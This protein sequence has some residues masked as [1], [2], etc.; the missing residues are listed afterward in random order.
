MELCCYSWTYIGSEFSK[1]HCQDQLL[2]TVR[3]P[4]DCCYIWRKLFTAL[5][6]H[7]EEIVYSFRPIA[8]P[9]VKCIIGDGS[10]TSFG[11]ID[12]LGSDFAAISGIPLMA[13]IFVMMYGFASLGLGLI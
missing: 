10:A 4:C 3:A 6:L 11:L 5:D 8:R 9:F 1:I 12:H 13:K 2:W 7:L